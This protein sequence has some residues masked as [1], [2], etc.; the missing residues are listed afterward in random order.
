MTPPSFL[1]AW[2][3]P[4][5]A[6]LALMTLLTGVAYPAL[7]AGLGAAAFPSQAQGSLLWEGD[8]AIGSS[9][10]GQPFDEP[11]YFW[12]RPSAALYDASASTGSNLGPSN[13]A[14]AE[15]VQ[16][17][18]ERLRAADPSSSSSEVP[19]ELVTTS[20]SGLDPHLSPAAARFQAPRVAK[21]RG[22]TPAQV[23]ALIEAHTE[24]EPLDLLGPPRVHVLRLN[25]ALDA[26]EVAP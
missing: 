22:L 11:G 10:V 6:S 13:P 7:V 4:A 8:R 2:L 24:R 16:R 9:L 14:L 18:V 23:L 26:R 19:V 20:A 12:P 25:L 15:A 5:A 1:P 17:R 3:R 21:A